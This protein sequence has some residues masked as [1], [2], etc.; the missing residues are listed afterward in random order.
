MRAAKLSTSFFRREGGDPPSVRPRHDESST[1]LA[2][3]LPPLRELCRDKTAWLE[4]DRLFRGKGINDFL[5][6]RI[7]AE[8][9][10]P[11]QQFQSAVTEE[12]GYLRRFHKI[13]QG[14]IFLAHPCRDDG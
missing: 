3:R 1:G 13:L 6:A 5:E 10:I 4:D 8:R 14:E 7:A 9:I 11:R 2:V 12:A